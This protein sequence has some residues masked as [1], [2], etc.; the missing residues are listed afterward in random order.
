MPRH[1]LHSRSGALIKV[2]PIVKLWLLRVLVPLGGLR[3]FIS[4]HGFSDDA[5]ANHLGLHKWVDCTKHEFDPKAVRAELREIYRAGEQRL[6]KAEPPLRL[7]RNIERLSAL[8]GLTDTDRHILE[9]VVMLKNECL[10]GNAV[11]YLGYLSSAKML[12]VLSAVLDIPVR[13]IRSSCSADGALRR[14]GLLTICPSGS[15]QLSG[16][17]E[18]LSD[19]FADHVSSSNTDPVSYIRDMVRPSSPPHLELTDYEHIGPVLAVLRPYLRQAIE[20]GRRGVNI[21]VHGTPGTGK[22]EL[23]KVLAKESGCELFEVA[24]EDEDEDP[25]KGEQ[26]LRAF[27]AAQC[28]FSR[29]RSLILFDEAE[30]IFNNGHT[31]FGRKS[32]AQT[33]KA[34][35]NRMLEEN[36]VPTV[37]LSNSV[38]SLDPAFVRRFDMVFELPVPPKRQRE[39]IIQET[40]ADL[41]DAPTI[42][43]LAESESLAPAVV[44]RA[45]SVVRA[46]R[47]ELGERGTAATVEFL[48]GHTLE[49]QGHDPVKKDD[50]TRLPEVYDPA[51]IHADADLEQV[52]AGLVEAKSGRLCLYGPPG[53]GKTAYGRWLAEQMGAP[54]LARRAS[55]LMSMWVGGSEKAVARTFAQADREG[56]LLLIDEVDS[57]LQD[58]RGASHSWEISLVNEMLTQMESFSGIFVA[59]TNLMDGLDAATLRRFD[60]K[61]RFDYLLPAQARALY[62]RYCANLG[63]EK[64]ESQ[65]TRLAGLK[66]LTPG[67]FATAIRQSRF[68]PIRSSEAL[69]DLLEGECAL[70]SGA[71][72]IGFVQ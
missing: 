51:F 18:L 7:R 3:E 70:K 54:V 66:K 50:P 22:T 48:I 58:R 15:S 6:S 40:C 23:A 27:R 61:V 42:R 59:S 63:M 30:D 64:P 33:R 45:S 68:R 37:W 24:S 12:H 11:D 17:F 26:R 65:L 71:R 4:E 32:T 36:P 10:L 38:G 62:L 41:L 47:E 43:R 19:Q 39:R 34:W 28:F 60:L 1:R 35:I 2:P 20:S 52:T 57:F 21:F 13:A 49:A 9:F 67:D 8:V 25:I 29:R 5:I 55:D 53:T 16:K 72:A 56:A 69:M 46:I 44:A 31:L 14:C